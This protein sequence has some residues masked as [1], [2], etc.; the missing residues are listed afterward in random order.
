MARGAVTYDD[1]FR[2]AVIADIA[3]GAES[4]RALERKWGVT[5]K[6]LCAW[7]DAH[8]GP[9]RMALAREALRDVVLQQPAVVLQP[10]QP[11]VSLGARV[12][13][14]LDEGLL[15]LKAIAAVGQDPEWVRAQP[16]HD[17]GIFF[18]ILADK[19]IRIAA[20]VEKER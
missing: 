4:L 6:T 20:A 18:G 1:A 11:T 8:I 19:V 3:L 14:F 5:V 13:E 16:A 9:D 17:L 15:S 7:R 2:A 10:Q 12:A